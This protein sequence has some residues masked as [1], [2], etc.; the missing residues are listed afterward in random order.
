MAHPWVKS[1]LGAANI[2]ESDFEKMSATIDKELDCCYVA[3]GEFAGS[4]MEKL[5][6]AAVAAVV[7]A[8]V[9]KPIFVRKITHATC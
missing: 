7:V 2:L 5:I 9:A 3:F 6:T 4:L 1:G 8:A